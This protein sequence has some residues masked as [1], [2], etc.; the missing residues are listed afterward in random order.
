MVLAAGL[1]RPAEASEQFKIARRIDPTITPPEGLFNPEV[2]ALF[3]AAGPAAGDKDGADEAGEVDSAPTRS[4]A[5]T[6]RRRTGQRVDDP[7]PD[8]DADANAEK[9]AGSSDGAAR[10]Y[11]VALGL[12]AGGGTAAG[13]IDMKG[14]A[15]NTAPGGFAVSALGH[16]TLAGGYFWSRSLLLAIEA[17]LQLVSGST[18][19]CDGSTCTDPSSFAAAALAKASYFLGEGP[20]KLFGTAGLG[21]GTIRQIV[22]LNGLP[23]CG[24]SGDQQ[25]FDTVTGGPV[26]LAA[27]GGA[28]YDIGPIVLLGGLT[29][30]MG[31]PDFMLNI[32]LTLGAGLR[33]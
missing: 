5:P 6:R 7:D 26:L 18:P 23:D 12:G 17:R 24:R 11:F 32:D 8:A 27:G 21:G 31:V 33:F 14:V 29:A 10:P 28:A 9:K 1:Q 30:N 3:A 2:A 4:T 25:C 13:H 20:L 15:P 22:K 16:V 19:H